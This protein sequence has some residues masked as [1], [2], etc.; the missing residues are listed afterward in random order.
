MFTED[1][2]KARDLVIARRKA[3]RALEEY[4]DSLR[5]EHGLTV[6]DLAGV[7]NVVQNTFLMYVIRDHDCER[8]GYRRRLAG[9]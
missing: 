6:T 5:Q 1:E 8:T 2:M 3:E 9:E 7:L 4:A